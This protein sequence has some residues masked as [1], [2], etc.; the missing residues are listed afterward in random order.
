MISISSFVIL[1]LAGTVHLDGE[2]VDQVACVARGVVHRGHLG[3]VEAGLVLEQRGKDL[4]R[5]VLRQQLGQDRHFVRLVFVERGRA[6][7]GFDDGGNELLRG[8][9]LGDDRLEPAVD[10]RDDVEFAGIDTCRGSC[11][12]IGWTRAKPG[13]LMPIS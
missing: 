13:V 5:D 6:R 8:R 3:G 11:C 2:G 10:Q 1:R 12:A 7:A 9:R 4:H